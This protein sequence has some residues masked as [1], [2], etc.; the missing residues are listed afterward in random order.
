[1]ELKGYKAFNWQINP[2]LEVSFFEKILENLPNYKHL[3][4]CCNFMRKNEKSVTFQFEVMLMQ[5][6]G[7]F[8]GHFLQTRFLN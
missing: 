8:R 4:H 6:L 5:N 1:M 7:L 3:K 2:N